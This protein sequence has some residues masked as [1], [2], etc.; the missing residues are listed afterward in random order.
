MIFK[1]SIKNVKG[2]LSHINHQTLPQVHFVPLIPQVRGL[3]GLCTQVCRS[4][5]LTRSYA[6]ESNPFEEQIMAVRPI[7]TCRKCGSPTLDT[8]DGLCYWCANEPPMRSVMDNARNFL[9]GR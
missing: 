2:S 9:I 3:S 4:G 7:R 1:P 6:P 8:L 5:A